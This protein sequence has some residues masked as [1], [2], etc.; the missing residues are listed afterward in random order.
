VTDVMVEASSTA[1]ELAS[2]A[3]LVGVVVA[4]RL[5]TILTVA[6]TVV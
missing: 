4:A 2:I 1:V 6:A 3:I 5:N